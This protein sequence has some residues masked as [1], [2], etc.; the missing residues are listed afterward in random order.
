MQAQRLAQRL[1][2]VALESGKTPHGVSLD[3]ALNL[4]EALS[5]AK[6][7]EADPSSV[8]IKKAPVKPRKGI[9]RSCNSTKQRKSQVNRRSR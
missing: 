9:S 6:A 2:G 1:N 4:A 7:E 3:V 8:S 5:G